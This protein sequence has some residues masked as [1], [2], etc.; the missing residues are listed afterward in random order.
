MSKKLILIVLSAFLGLNLGA[1]NKLLT[2]E[3]AVLKSRTTLAPERL[4]QLQWIP[5]SNLFSYV[6]KRQGNEVLITQNAVGL[7]RDTI[8]TIEEF[9]FAF[10]NL[11]TKSKGMG[12][13]PFISWINPSSFR[14][15][16]SNA[17]YLFNLSNKSVKVLAIAPKDAENLDFDPASNRLAYTQYNNFFVNDDPNSN[18]RPANSDNG[19]IVNKFDEITKDGNPNISYGKAAHRNEFGITKGTF[20][21]PNGN[22]IAFYKLMESMVSDYPLMNVKLND[23]L[24]D[25]L[26]QPTL[27]ENIKYPMA[28]NR[29]HQAKVMLYDF[30]KKR[31][32]E[33]Q[34]T[35]D[36]EQYYTNISWSPDEEYVY[37]AV[38]NRDQNEM[39]LQQFDA[40]TGAFIRTLFTETHAKYVEPEKS[41]YFIGK[42]ASKFIWFSERDG[43]NHMY[44]YNNKGEMLKQ[45]T[46]GKMTVLDILATDPKG[47]QL[48]YQAVSENGLNKY[49]YKL[50]L[51]SGVSTVLNKLEGQHNGMV[52]EDGQ[53][54][55]EQL[56]STSIPKRYLLLD[57]KG[58][59]IAILFNSINPLREYK[60]CTVKLFSI[61][62]TDKQVALNCRMIY[63]PNFDSTKKYPVIVYVYGG[64]HAQMI[65]N[66][67]LG[68]ADMWLYYMAQQGY[69]T[70]TLDNRGSMNRGLEFENATFRNLGKVEVEDQLAGV[71]Y[72][73]KQKYVDTKRLGVY[74][75][76]FGGFMTTSLMTKTPDVY[77]VGVAGGAVIDWRMYEI[78]YTERYMDM[79]QTNPEGYHNADLTNFAKDLK[80]KLLLIH[81]TNDNV[82]LWQHTLTYLKKCVDE[83]VMVDYFVYP[84]HEHNVLG[85]DRVHLMKKIT[86]Y[87]KENL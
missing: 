69:I 70:F 10:R 78:M 27:F 32:L 39:K 8:L 65:T 46:T 5:Q 62:S 85:P 14:F 19:Q 67:W 20:F 41:M 54:I 80:G 13:F 77:K 26:S 36:E 56:S 42:D 30:K 38:V 23:T 16:Y 15:M 61:P 52:S 18:P 74:G 35:G 50:D 33:V 68:Q 49:V 83:G 12:R 6:G 58:K 73:T 40:T 57:Q 59:E 34:T 11:E 81:G 3:D 53:F 25:K 47:T 37:I 9:S 24:G 72:L 17:Y 7:K 87:F 60:E 76:S 51:K 75:W 66:N 82:V 22:R 28:G 21:S 64:P 86:L 84:G 2:V 31:L 71:S 79:P 63:P 48:F 1:Q 43:Y 45:L 29:S 4:S 44:L 55:L